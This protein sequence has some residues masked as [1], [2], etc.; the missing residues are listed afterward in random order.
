MFLVDKPYISD[1]FKTT[2]QHHAIP[3]IQTAIADQFHLHEG[4]TMASETSAIKLA[5]QLENPI[6]YSTS[7]NAISWISQ[8]LPFSHLTEKIYLFKNKFKFRDL[9]K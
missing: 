9:P 8:N 5:K 7:E 6:F 2:V 1:F 4:T 3:V